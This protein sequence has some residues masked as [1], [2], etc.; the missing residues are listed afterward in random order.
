MEE[1]HRESKT[2]QVNIYI[3]IFLYEIFSHLN[4][5]HKNPSQNQNLLFHFGRNFNFILA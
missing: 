3:L 1:K 5:Q 2:F 4:T